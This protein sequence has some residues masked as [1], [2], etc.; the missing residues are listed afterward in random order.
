MRQLLRGKWDNKTGL[1]AKSFEIYK[2]VL[3]G[4]H[5]LHY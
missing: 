4:G 2:E 1:L 5:T 3:H